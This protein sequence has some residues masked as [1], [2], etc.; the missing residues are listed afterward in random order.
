MMRRPW[1]VGKGRER[2]A[3]AGRRSGATGMVGGPWAASCSEDRHKGQDGA[4]ATPG[5]VGSPRLARTCR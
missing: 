5:S 3:W 1:A 2:E 4:A